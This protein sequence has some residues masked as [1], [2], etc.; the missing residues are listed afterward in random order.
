M[1]CL[2]L[3]QNKKGTLETLK[4][5]GCLRARK[6]SS[7]KILKC[8]SVSFICQFI[9]LLRKVVNPLEN[10]DINKNVFIVSTKEICE[11]LGLSDRRIQQLAKED[12]LVR[13]SHGKY[14][15]PGS[16]QNYINYIKEQSKTG[17]ELNKVEEETLLVRVRRQ[18]AE[19]ELDI[20]QGNVHLSED[21]EKVMSD[22]LSSFRAQLLVIPGK[23]SPQLM[24][25]NEIEPIK[26]ILK[27][28]IHEALQ[29]MSEYDPTAFY[30]KTNITVEEETSDTKMRSDKYD[31]PKYK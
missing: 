28:Y 30:N 27:N 4:N 2:F 24:G 25:M 5:S 31:D 26:A 12:I 22:M 17:E 21:V 14:D 3:C 16:I 10:K 8:I 1:R 7:F 13:V 6:S 15:L 23:A 19:I 29:E 11:I 18:K 20:M 9:T